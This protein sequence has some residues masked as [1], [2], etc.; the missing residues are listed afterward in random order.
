MF[1]NIEQE[2]GIASPHSVIETPYGIFSSNMI[3]HDRLAYLINTVSKAS[4]ANTST[5]L[6]NLAVKNSDV[7]ISI[8]DK[9]KSLLNNDTNQ[10]MASNAYAQGS[11]YRT[12]G[13]IPKFS[14]N[15]H[16]RG[17]RRGCR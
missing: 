8:K 2:F 3:Y 11:G 10:K 1:A 17:P 9:Y 14:F 6:S 16:R 5:E 7:N 13:S 12:E 15:N 4:V